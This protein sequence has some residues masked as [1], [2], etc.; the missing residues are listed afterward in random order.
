MRFVIVDQMPPQ[1]HVTA[2]HAIFPLREAQFVMVE[3]PFEGLGA[4][5]VP[6]IE[7]QLMEGP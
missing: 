2:T 5:R 6:V 4:V 3:H 7:V 1:F